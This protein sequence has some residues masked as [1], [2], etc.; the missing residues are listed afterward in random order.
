MSHFHLQLTCKSLELCV[1]DDFSSVEIE[2]P[3]FPIFI[4]EEFVDAYL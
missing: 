2:L 3:L 4:L 1:L